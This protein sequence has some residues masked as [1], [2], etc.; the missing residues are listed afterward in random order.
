MRN[1][2]LVAKILFVL[3][4]VLAV[5]Y[6]ILFIYSAFCLITGIRTEVSNDG[7][8]MHI[9]YPFIDSNFMNVDN[10]LNYKIFSFLVPLGLY[11]LFFY[12]AS[13]I[14]KV[15]TQ[16]KLFTKKN[17]KQLR[18]FYVCNL[19]IPF[20]VAIIASFFVEVDES[21]WMLVF[22]HSILGVIT[23]FLAQIFY[24]GLGLQD[25]QDLII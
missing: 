3:C 4:K 25:E 9:L 18:W 15:F 17:L 23:Y 12:L 10:H 2:K 24:Q 6:L 8:I 1:S 14:S 5:F 19:L 13:N 7:N 22:V 21:V 20:P 11:A 16:E